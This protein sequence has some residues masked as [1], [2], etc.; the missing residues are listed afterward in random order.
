MPDA[1]T[2]PVRDWPAAMSADTLA[3]YLDVSPRTVASL[4]ASGKLPASIAVPGTRCR[5]WRRVD[6]DEAV[7][8][9]TGGVR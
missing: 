6:V 8:S 2:K 4:A 9:W 3:E 7:A 5:R 1:P